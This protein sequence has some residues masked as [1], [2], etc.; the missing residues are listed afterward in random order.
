[1]E[2]FGVIGM[3]LGAMGLVFGI[4]CL[5][6]IEKLIKDLKTR[7]ILEKDYKQ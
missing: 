4:I 3:S 5:S 7:E 6:K 1:M 2:V